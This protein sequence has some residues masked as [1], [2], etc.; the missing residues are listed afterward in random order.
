MHPELRNIW[1]HIRDVG[2]TVLARAQSNLFIYNM[3][4][5]TAYPQGIFGV[6]QAAHAAELLMKAAI[7]QEH[8]LLIFDKLPREV[9]AELLDY[10][11][12]AKSG[13]SID[14]QDI[15]QRLWAATGYKIEDAKCFKEFGSLRNE[16]QHFATP[17]VRFDALGGAFIYSVLDPLLDHF[18]G[19]C[20]VTHMDTT[21]HE[22]YLLMALKNLKVSYR[23]PSDGSWDAHEAAAG[24]PN[25]L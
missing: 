1:Q 12:L 17:D 10:E 21:D 5:D 2:L 25:S 3:M 24:N 16:I 7:A 19:L 15:P 22:P 13:R 4:Q 6:I 14:Y 20:A 11:L 18:W 9:G 23:L 8:P